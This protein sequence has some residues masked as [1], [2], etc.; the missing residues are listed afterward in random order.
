MK[1]TILLLVFFVSIFSFAQD[2]K[3]IDSLKKVTTSNI[4]KDE[5]AIA[6]NI[7][8][9]K[10]LDSNL[11][12]SKK[13]IKELYK[14]NNDNSCPKCEVLGDLNQGNLYFLNYDIK[15]AISFFQ[16]S[17]KKALKI[18]DYESYEAAK[19]QLI[20]TYLNTSD[21]ANGEKELND[22]L[23]F[24]KTNNLNKDIEYIYLHFGQL[25]IL[26]SFNK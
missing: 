13:C 11:E 25:N 19:T 8:F 6:Y 12:E 14:L 15:N 20:Q 17:A 22:L 18:K 24:K 4:S 21:I 26:K 5:K 3:A 7:L 9:Q 23:N 10:T 16:K 1:K 2:E